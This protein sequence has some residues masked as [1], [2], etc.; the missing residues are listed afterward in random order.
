MKRVVTIL[1]GAL[2]AVV[3]LLAVTPASG[4]KWFELPLQNTQAG[5][6]C[7]PNTDYV[8]IVTFIGLYCASHHDCHTVWA[9]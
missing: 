4:E 8:L 5:S 7:Y 9:G 6:L 3:L 2:S 1:D